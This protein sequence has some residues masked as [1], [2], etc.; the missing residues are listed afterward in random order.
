MLNYLRLQVQNL[1][2]ETNDTTSILLKNI[3]SKSV[4]FQP[5]QFLTFF[6]NVNGDEKKYFFSITSL[7][8]E[9]PLIRITVKE[10]LNN[11]SDNFIE[12]IKIGDII[13]TLPPLD[14]ICLS[15]TNTHPQCIRGQVALSETSIATLRKYSSQEGRFLDLSAINIPII[16]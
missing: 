8:E 7:P 9:L 13:K 2:K 15:L 12:R 1:I 5:G 4:N 14:N 3:N 11:S 6:L 16:L 10:K